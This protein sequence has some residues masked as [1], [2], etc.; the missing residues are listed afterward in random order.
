[1]ASFPDLNVTTG[2]CKASLP[3]KVK[4]TTSPT[5]ANVL[6]ELLDAIATLLND[7]DPLSKVT[8]PEP[9]VTAVPLFPAI[10]LKAMV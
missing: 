4:V 8:L 1:M 2:V 7:G 6:V 10:S 3:V 9:L 5:L